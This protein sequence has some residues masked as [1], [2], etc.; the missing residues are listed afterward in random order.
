[1]TGTE[2]DGYEPAKQYHDPKGDAH[3]S[4]GGEEYCDFLDSARSYFMDQPQ[5]R[6]RSRH[7]LLVHDKSKVHTSKAV[8]QHLKSRHLDVA[9]M[10]PRSPDLQPLDYGIFSA[11]KNQLA[12]HA[13]RAM[14]WTPKVLE[15]KKLISDA[16]IA[17][18]IHGFVDRLEACISAGGGHIEQHLSQLKRMKPKA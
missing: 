13:G 16:D 18:S 5:F 14:A 10:P 12:K 8:E 11:S 1:V 15:L 7:A 9:V 6:S 17:P 2:Y 3:A 4:M